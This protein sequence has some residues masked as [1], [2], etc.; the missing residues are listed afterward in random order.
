MFTAVTSANCVMVKKMNF[1][2]EIA[3]I[4]TG[5]FAISISLRRPHKL[6]ILH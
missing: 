6:S 2:Y 1:Y 4:G 5:L 3:A